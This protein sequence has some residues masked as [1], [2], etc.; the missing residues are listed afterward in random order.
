MMLVTGLV[1]FLALPAYAAELL[2]VTGDLEI[3]PTETTVLTA[4]WNFSQPVAYYFWHIEGIG[5]VDFNEVSGSAG[6][7]SYVF[8]PAALGSYVV[9][10]GI[11]DGGDFW[12]MQSVTV[13]VEPHKN[14]GQC[15]KDTAQSTPSG[16][17]K[18]KVVSEKAHQK[19]C[20][21]GTTPPPV[22]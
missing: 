21:C 10:F 8:G 14:H 9:T 11:G 19:G 18:V 13:T 3:T 1:L 4:E 16:K 17:G 12:A 5:Y 22:F 7:L 20:S 2:E 15:V 6:T